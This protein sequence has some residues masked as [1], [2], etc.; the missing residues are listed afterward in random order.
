MGRT[1]SA[2]LLA[3]LLAA[4]GGAADVS[5]APVSQPPIKG[6]DADGILQIAQ[7]IADGPGISIEEAIG[8]AGTGPLLING[9]LFVDPDGTVLLCSAIAESFPPQCGGTR[10]S[11][12]GLD[13]ESMPDL[14]EANGVRWAEQVQLL[15]T[16]VLIET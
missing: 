15:G 3:L 12:R 1:I 10:L 5:D 2:I 14:Q 7:G 9:S 8:Q 6:G 16:V 4:C 11:V 13:L